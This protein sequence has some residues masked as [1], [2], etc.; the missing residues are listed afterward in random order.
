MDISIH[1]PQYLPW[2]PYF[3]KI[4]QSDLFIFLDNVD[5]QKMDYRIE[6]R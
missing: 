3:R 4:E 6:I 2:V 1:Q 5:F